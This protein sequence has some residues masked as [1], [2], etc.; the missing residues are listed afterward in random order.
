M[1]SLGLD[2]LAGG[3][4]TG[5][6][7]TIMI[8]F[9]R[10][11]KDADDRRDEASKI[12]MDAALEREARAW[13]ERDKALAERD[14]ARAETERVRGQLEAEQRVQREEMRRQEQELADLRRQFRLN[15]QEE[16]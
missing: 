9:L 4:V 14:A 13:A 11:T 8:V 16:P 15:P 1:E 3:G 5:M 10:R 12:V 6:L 2:T 7:V